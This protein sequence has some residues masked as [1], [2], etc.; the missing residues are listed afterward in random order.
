MQDDRMSHSLRDPLLTQ[1]DS[2][3]LFASITMAARSGLIPHL[4][5]PT[6]T[7][8]GLSPSSQSPV[9][10]PMYM[11]FGSLELRRLRVLVPL[12]RYRRLITKAK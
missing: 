10:S 4:P 3:R 8:F 7:Y 6:S 12:L 2:L 11:P 9:G 5:H 1:D